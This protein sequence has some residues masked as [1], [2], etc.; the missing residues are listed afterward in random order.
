MYDVLNK[1]TIIFEIPPHLFVAKS[2][3]V[4]LELGPLPFMSRC[5]CL[6]QM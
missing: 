5:S 1:D 3:I 6:M 2:G 4:L